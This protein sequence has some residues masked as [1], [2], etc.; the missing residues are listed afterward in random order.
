MMDEER[1]MQAEIFLG[2][3]NKIY[4]PT[5]HIQYRSAASATTATL[6]SAILSTVL[7]WAQA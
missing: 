4:F 6:D 3:K 1:K 7:D 5:L 2:I